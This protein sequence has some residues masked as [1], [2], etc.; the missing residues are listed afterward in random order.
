[1]N[2][3]LRDPAERALLEAYYSKRRELDS[4]TPQ[5][6]IDQYSEKV[7][8]AEERKLKSRVKAKNYYHDVVKADP[9]KS[10][11]VRER[12]KA[13]AKLR[14]DRVKTE[15]LQYEN[16]AIPLFN[17]PQYE[18]PE[19]RDDGQ[20]EDEQDD[21]QCE[22]ERDERDC[23]ERDCDERDCDEREDEGQPKKQIKPRFMF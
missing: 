2:I 18:L 9:E 22:D 8:K 14:R 16:N 10:E 12:N 15:K 19:L 7:R 21:G 20:C 11:A 1:M 23:D 5:A 13:N 4:T 6:V 3:N 17:Q